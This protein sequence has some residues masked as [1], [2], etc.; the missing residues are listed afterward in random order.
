MTIR[1]VLRRSRLG[2]RREGQVQAGRSSCALKHRPRWRST[3]SQSTEP[4]ARRSTFCLR[5]SSRVAGF[6]TPAAPPVPTTRGS[7]S[8]RETSR[9]RSPTQTTTFA[10]SSTTGTRSS[11]LPSTKSSAG[12]GKDHQDSYPIASSERYRR[13]LD[14]IGTDRASRLA[15]HLRR[16][17]PQGDAQRIRRSLQPLSATPIARS[18][19]SRTLPEGLRIRVK[20][21]RPS[22]SAALVV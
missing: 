21:A 5:S 9:W 7:P 17:P 8:R 6:T 16:G 10:S 3:S 15:A 4:G 19:D 22:K 20:F 12:M 18:H 11:P 13:A 2:P 14:Q 1:D